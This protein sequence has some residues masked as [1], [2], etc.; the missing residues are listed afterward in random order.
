MSN[1]LDNNHLLKSLYQKQEQALEH[2]YLLYVDELYAYGVSVG[3]TAET[4]ED[5]IHDVFVK[6]CA[7]PSQFESVD[8]LKFYLLR[9]VKNGLYDVYKSAGYNREQSVESFSFEMEAVPS[10]LSKILNVEEQK[11]L[12]Q[13]VNKMLSTLTSRQREAVYLRYIQE[14]DYSRISELMNINIHAVRKLVSRALQQ[15]KQTKLS[16]PLLVLLQVYF[17]SLGSMK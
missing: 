8:H 11:I 12:E 13:K 4:V 14:L 3:G 15:M 7:Y 6:L 17:S 1:I 2:F 10:A 16:L 5:V 9:S